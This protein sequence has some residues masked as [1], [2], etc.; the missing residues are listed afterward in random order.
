ML[1]RLN[2]FISINA[3]VAHDVDMLPGSIYEDATG[4]PRQPGFTFKLQLEGKARLSRNNI[5]MSSTDTAQ[6]IS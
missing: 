1:F 5:N 3:A 6:E 2:K 4:H